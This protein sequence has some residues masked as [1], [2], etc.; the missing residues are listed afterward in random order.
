MSRFQKS[1]E[2]QHARAILLSVKPRFADQIMAGTKRVEFRRSWARE[3]VELLIIY[4]S[5][6]VQR[7]VGVVEV[8]GMIND[9]PTKIWAT[10]KHQGPGISRKELMDYFTG[11]HRGY[12]VLLGQI[13]APPRAIAPKSVFKGFRAPQS[14]RYLTHTE[15]RS[16]GK[17]FKSEETDR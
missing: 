5:A 13:T 6:P 9:S 14:F 15:L 2:P 7:I 16:L 12:G 4:S 8:I 3:P 1:L 11:K 10:C 17:K